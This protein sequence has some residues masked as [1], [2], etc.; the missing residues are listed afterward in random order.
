[1]TVSFPL[2]FSEHYRVY[3]VAFHRTKAAWIAY[4]FFSLVPILICAAAVA[5]RGWALEEVAREN[6]PLL[7]GGPAFCIVVL[8]LLH[9][10]NVRQARAG[11]RTTDGEQHLALSS[12]GIRAWGALHNTSLQWNAVHEVV[13]T[14]DYFLIYLSKVQFFFLPKT[15]LGGATELAAARCLFEDA[16]SDRAKLLGHRRAAA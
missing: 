7:V 15:A 5:F 14:R 1:M 4:A 6:A 8:P 13:E 3:R 12:D 11:N 16:I 2:G 9:R 10:L